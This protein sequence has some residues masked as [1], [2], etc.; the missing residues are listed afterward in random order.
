MLNPIVV[1]QN[2]ILVSR[3]DNYLQLKPGKKKIIAE[4]LLKVKV[5]EVSYVTFLCLN[6]HLEELALGNLYNEGIIDSLSEVERTS[7]KDDTFSIYIKKNLPAFKEYRRVSS[8]SAKNFPVVQTERTGDI[9]PISDNS[10]VSM[11]R[12]WT[13]MEE[14]KEQSSLFIRIGGVHSALF[15]HNDLSIFAEDIGRHNCID[16]IVGKLLKLGKL[17]LVAE[18][19]MLSSGRIS[20][21]IISKV[22]RL[23]IP[24]FVSRTTPTA[25]AVELAEKYNITLIGYV[26]GE[27][28]VIYSGRERV[29]D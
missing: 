28:G 13:L 21:E 23:K 7:I 20:T 16:K 8:T 18:S 10:K 29:T 5:N 24:V 1:N 25:N 17:E 19:L 22:I 27:K 3:Q 14:F 6:E 2:V 11:N 4:T 12:I 26:R 9:E 15:Y